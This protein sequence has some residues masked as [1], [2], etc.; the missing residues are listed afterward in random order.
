YVQQQV[1]IAN[2][3]TASA[4]GTVL[5]FLTLA[6][7]FCLCRL[8]RSEEAIVPGIGSQK[9]VSRTARLALDLPT[10]VGIV[11]TFVVFLFLL[12]PLVMV[13]LLSFT[14]TTYLRF[15]P[16]GFSLRWY[17][18]FFSDPAWLASAWL[19]FKVALLSAVFATAL[20]LVTAIG[21]ERGN[22]PGRRV[23]ASLF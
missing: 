9:G 5:L 13:V 23:I 16:L 18:E 22:L 8:F 21:L 7:Y 11:T 17:S 1:M 12:V 14:T 2:W 6:V 4:M 10:T 19:S 3:G 15:P 20:G